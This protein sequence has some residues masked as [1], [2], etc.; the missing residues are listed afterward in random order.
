MLLKISAHEKDRNLANLEDA[1]M[2]S[3]DMLRSI[4]LAK[5]FKIKE[6]YYK[7]ILFY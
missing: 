6:F 7:F 5:N 3:N 1:P 2:I 4:I